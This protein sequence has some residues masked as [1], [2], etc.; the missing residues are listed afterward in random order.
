MGNECQKIMHAN[1]IRTS[2]TRAMACGLI[3]EE[4][5]EFDSVVE[6]PLKHEE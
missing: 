4:D 2:S 5:E 3:A 6:V 1:K